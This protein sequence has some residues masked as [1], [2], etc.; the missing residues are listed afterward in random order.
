M[1]YLLS[2]TFPFIGNNIEEIKSKIT[3]GK[4][5]FDYDSFT[6]VS[7]DAKDLIKKCLRNDKAL[8]ISILDTVKHPFF[9]DLKD[10]KVYLIDEKKILENLK[11]Q[12][13]RHIFYQIVLN[14]ISYHFNDTELLI[15]LSRIFYKIDRNSDGK[16]TKEDLM[17]AYE[18]AG[19]KIDKKD[20]EKIIK[21]VDFDRNGFIEYD[22]FIRV[23]IPEDR[24]FTVD[25]LK[26]AFNLF[27]KSKE[28]SI[29]YLNVVE[30]VESE[31]RINPK[32]ID[33][34]KIEVAKMGDEKINFDQF[35]N[36]MVK[37]SVQ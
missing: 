27:D 31:E 5:I 26:N 13:E 19:E 37:L 20:L 29:S 9:D 34:F 25:N 1:H 28:G 8:R 32:M 36:L 15:E 6:G 14:F 18:E 33:L 21:T 24:L 10:S 35:Y 22:E 3:S 16:I 7:E 23:C 17:N 4:L 12:K 2:G 11:S 30:A